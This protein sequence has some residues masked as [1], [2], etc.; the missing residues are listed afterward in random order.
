MDAVQRM[1]MKAKGAGNLKSTEQQKVE[2]KTIE[3]KTVVVIEQAQ[4]QVI[5]VPSYNPTVVYG[6]PAYAYPP[7]AYPPP[8]AYV[9]GMA[10]SFGVG[11]AMGAAWGQAG[12]TTVDGATAITSTST[13]TTTSSTITTERI[14]TIR[15]RGPLA[16]VT[17][18]STIPNTVA[19]LPTQTG[20]LRTNMAALPGA[21]PWPRDR[22]TRARTKG[23]SV[24]DNRQAQW[25]AAPTAHRRARWIA[26]ASTVNKPGRWIVAAQTGNS[27][28]Q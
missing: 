3:N 24:A 7:I 17:T 4:P 22:Q 10:I 13:S 9:A 14:S 18:G 20:P 28:A 16:E 12:G 27:P 2:T 11:M 1:R 23:N 8:G 5:Y 19:A 25:I 26:A 21:I 15:R 6:P